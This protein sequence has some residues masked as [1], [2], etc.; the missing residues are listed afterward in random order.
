MTNETYRMAKQSILAAQRNEKNSCKIFI[1]PSNKGKTHTANIICRDL[2]ATM[3]PVMS[4]S[5]QRTWFVE[6]VNKP[7]FILDDP[8]D[9]YIYLDRFSL[10]SILKNLMGQYVK[11]ARATKFDFNVPLPFQNK[12]CILLF[13]NEEQYNLIRKDLAVTGLGSR[14]DIY[15]S[16]HS[17][18]TIKNIETYYAAYNYSSSKLPHFKNTDDPI[19]DKR[20][21]D[22]YKNKTYFI[23]DIE[24]EDE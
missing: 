20:Y 5:E 23:E 1:R 3:I 14:A 4:I 6:R 2:G 16:K 8:S 11:G 15:F 12:V 21:L 13:M 7:Y 17:D 9:W 18:E 24:F 19:F 10:L 22:S